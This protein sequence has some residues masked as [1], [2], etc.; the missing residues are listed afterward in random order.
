MKRGG[1]E[2]AALF[3]TTMKSVLLLGQYS[4]DS[5][6]PADMNDIPWDQVWCMNFY[7]EEYEFKPDVVFQIHRRKSM[8][9]NWEHADLARMTAEYNKSGAE[10][11]VTDVFDEYAK[12]SV[13][14]IDE[15]VK[16]LGR[17]C[18]T[19]TVVYMLALA[20][21]RGFESIAMRGFNMV[22]SDE[23]ASQVFPMMKAIGRIERRGVKIDAPKR[24]KWE[25][26]ADAMGVNLRSKLPTLKKMYHEL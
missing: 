2:P 7:Y 25:E 21:L 17:D 3:F 13:Y 8:F 12:A 24:G 22:G 26:Y 6:I 1:G 10:V 14:P 23:Y 18:F 15:A 11:M 16:L 5:D 19:S 20:A 9:K 4:S